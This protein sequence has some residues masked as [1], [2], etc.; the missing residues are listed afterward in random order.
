[1]LVI[2]TKDGKAIEAF[3]HTSGKGVVEIDYKNPL[4]TLYLVRA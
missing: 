3:Y 4:A 1:M 2:I